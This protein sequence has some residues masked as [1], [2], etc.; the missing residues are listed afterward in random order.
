MKKNTGKRIAAL[1]LMLLMTLAT[2]TGCGSKSAGG[3][4]S[5]KSKS[6]EKSAGLT[7][8][9]VSEFRNLSWCAAYVADANGY[10]KNEG[11]DVK[12]A[13]YNDG[14]VAFQGMHGGDSD[15]C[16][17]SQEPV[18]KAEEEGLK[19]KIIYTVLDTRL[20]G[21]VGA[22]NIKEVKDLKGK[23]IFAGM[24]GSAPYSFVSAILRN[25]GLDPEKDVTFVNMDYSASMT[26]L[27]KGQIQASYINVDNRVEIK[28]MDVNILVDTSEKADAQKYLKSKEFPGEIICTTAKF[29]KENP[30]TV[31]AFV[32]AISKATEWINSHSSAET[33]K[34]LKPYFNGMTEDVLQQKIDILKPALTKTGLI[35]ENAE[36]Y[37]QDFIIN[38]GTTK[39]QIPYQDVID[40]TYVNH[41]QKNK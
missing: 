13:M 22:A 7:K 24:Q 10:Y 26:A 11:L 1:A 33:A 36:K 20:Y 5:A 27:K 32:N 8:V 23:T 40:M 34:V 9:T 19:S 14:P 18:L 28:D 15:F 29:V 3:T 2:V 31:Q 25:A 17:L 30:K 12:F 6:S 35:S 38:C 41:Y 37:V 39:K 4:S 16:L 21:F